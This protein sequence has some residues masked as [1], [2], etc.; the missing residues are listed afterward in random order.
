LFIITAQEELIPT[1][2]SA[3]QQADKRF[4]IL[5]LHTIMSMA[6]NTVLVQYNSY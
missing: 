2:A 3:Q 6:S 5:L 1:S 4:M